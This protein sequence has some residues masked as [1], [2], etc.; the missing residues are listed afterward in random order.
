MN[1]HNFIPNHPQMNQIDAPQLAVRNYD[2]QFERMFNDP[3]SMPY[4]IQHLPIA[5]ITRIM[6]KSLKPKV[7]KNLI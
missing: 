3:L 2:P 5:N 1:N 7:K 4:N 6:K